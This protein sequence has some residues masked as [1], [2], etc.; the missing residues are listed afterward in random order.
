[1]AR[2]ALFVVDTD[3]RVG[4]ARATDDPERLPDVDCTRCSNGSRRHSS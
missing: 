1:V 3:R 4:D 2:R